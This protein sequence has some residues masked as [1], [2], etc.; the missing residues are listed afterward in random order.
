MGYGHFDSSL[1]SSDLLLRRQYFKGLRKPVLYS[2]AIFCFSQYNTILD[3]I[4]VG[5]T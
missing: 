2:G 1:K 5:G 3:Q 4:A